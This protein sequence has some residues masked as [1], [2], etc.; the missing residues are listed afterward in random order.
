MGQSF[1][2][3]HH[4]KNFMIC[5]DN[6][7]TN[8]DKVYEL[9]KKQ[10][11]EKSPMYPGRRTQNL[12]EC[13]DTE[14]KNFALFFAKKLAQEIFPGIS[15]FLIDIRFHI[16][17]DFKN[18]LLNSGWIHSD[19]TNLA[20][21]VYLNKTVNNFE[22][23]TSIFKQE[24][25]KIFKQQDYP[26]RQDFNL[27]GSSVDAYVSDLQQNYNSFSETVKFGN[28]YNRIVAYDASLFHRP[29]NY[30]SGVIEERTTLIFFIDTYEYTA[31]LESNITSTWSDL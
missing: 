3:M 15:K 16:N 6:F 27:H 19:E 4:Y 12:L 28:R 14:T 20:G 11:Y 2:N 31:T 23:G 5:K 21:I 22:N 25:S 18:D 13:N 17:D 26:S 10:C 9:T 29:N 8:P 7:F 24:N 1:T 30:S